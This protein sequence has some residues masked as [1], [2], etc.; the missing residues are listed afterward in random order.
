MFSGCVTFQVLVDDKGTNLMKSPAPTSTA[1]IGGFDIL[2]DPDFTR[3][4]YESLR[5]LQDPIPAK[6]ATRVK[7][8]RGVAYVRLAVDSKKGVE[9]RGPAI[10]NGAKASAPGLEVKIEDVSVSDRDVTLTVEVTDSNITVKKDRNAL[11]PETGGRVILRDS[12]GVDI[13]AKVKHDTGTTTMSGP[14]MAYDKETTKFKVEGTLAS[15]VSLVAIEVWE[16]SD[17]EEI[18]IPFDLKDIPIRKVK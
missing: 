3:P 2:G 16:P 14:V 9:I 10:K 6:D 18:K 12:R 1:S 7:V 13:G 8:C 17:I 11:Y 4:L 5:D 15:G